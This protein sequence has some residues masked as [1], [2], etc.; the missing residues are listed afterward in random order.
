MARGKLE[1]SFALTLLALA[2]ASLAAGCGEI[3]PKY[4]EYWD[5]SATLAAGAG[6]QTMTLTGFDSHAD[7]RHTPLY[8][9][10]EL[11][12]HMSPQDSAAAGFEYLDLIVKLDG[13]VGKLGK[14]AI[15]G[16]SGTL[17][18]SFNADYTSND[19]KIDQDGWT[20]QGEVTITGYRFS[21]A[22]EPE[23]CD[24]KALDEDAQGTFQLT[25][26]GPG[27][28]RFVLRDGKL[29]ITIYRKYAC[30]G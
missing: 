10:K 2:A 11:L 27:G 9:Q 16:F 19:V 17:T 26:S 12:L 24:D 4:V 20:L 7:W 29:D 14:R 6:D 21:E 28:K 3:G 30:L 15:K 18:Q 22:P 8:D 13:P 23:G 5:G 25:L 1:L